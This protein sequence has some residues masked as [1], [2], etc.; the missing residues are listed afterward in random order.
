[1]KQNALHVRRNEAL[2]V[3]KKM[4]EE[5]NSRGIQDRIEE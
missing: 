4:S 5:V 1:M 2:L 3:T